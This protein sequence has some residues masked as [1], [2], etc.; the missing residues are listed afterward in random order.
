MIATR[1]R[2]TTEGYVFTGVC[3]SGGG[4]GNPSP[5]LGGKLSPG[6]LGGWGWGGT[7]KPSPGVPLR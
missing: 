7:P 1:V 2:S 3:L 6:D 4:G 5:S